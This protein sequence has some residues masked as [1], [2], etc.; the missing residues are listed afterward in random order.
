MSKKK[1]Q[2]PKGCTKEDYDKVKAFMAALITTPKDR[3]NVRLAAVEARKQKFNSALVIHVANQEWQQGFN[4][5]QVAPPKEKEEAAG[6]VEEKSEKKATEAVQTSI[7]KAVV[8][9]SEDKI[10]AVL[11]VGKG[12]VDTIGKYVVDYGFSD[13]TSFLN[14]VLEF[15][16]SYHDKVE[17]LVDDLAE[18]KL[19]VEELTTHLGMFVRGEIRED[20]AQ[21]RVVTMVLANAGAGKPSSPQEIVDLL[22]AF[23]GGEK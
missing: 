8:K 14:E 18:Y 19:A 3:E 4:P 13:V 12:V 15:Y 7:T 21:N 17:N 10:T 9:E 1:S 16:L 5:S 6:P 11:E 23:R 22:A 2:L 20:K